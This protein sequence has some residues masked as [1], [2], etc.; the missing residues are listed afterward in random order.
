MGFRGPRGIEPVLRRVSFEV[1]RG[2]I[3][4]LVG[5]SG[6]GKSLTA[7]SLMG[8]LPAQGRILGG[9]IH[10]AGVAELSTLDEKT[11]RRLRGRRMAM[12]FQEPAG[13]L[14]PVLSIG[15]QIV[16]VLRL[17]RGLR[18]R[19]ARAEAIEL[20]R[21]VAMP[22]PE[23]RLG[24]YPH[25]LSGGQ[26]QRAMIAMALAGNPDLL[27]ADEPTT[28]LDVTVQAQVLELLLDLRRDLGLSVLL[29]T[30]DLGVVAETADRVGVMYAGE[31]VE[32]APVR[33]LFERPAHP[34]TRALLSAL[35]RLAGGV[36][37]GIP[38]RPPE[39]A[40]RPMGCAFAPRCAEV[41]ATCHET[42]PPWV[43]RGEDHGC[44][45]LLAELPPRAPTGTEG[46]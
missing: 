29:I 20:L 3:F 1:R 38:G 32:L 25:Q 18:R 14:N 37:K 19:A 44:R 40:D 2:E 21:R 13:A 10:L 8:L 16:E 26:Q 41:L 17:H 5:E 34:Y 27:I 6:C 42:V 30:H 35:P 28:A 33:D 31:M 46:E 11:R 9:A 23:E 4:G 7:L 45:C 36:P 24:A 39:P 22:D 43:G 15:F 12:I